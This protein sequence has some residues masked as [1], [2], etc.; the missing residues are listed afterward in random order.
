MNKYYRNLM[1]TKVWGRGVALPLHCVKCMSVTLW[2]RKCG[3]VSIPVGNDQGIIPEDLDDI[4]LYATKLLSKLLLFESLFGCLDSWAL[5]FSPIFIPVRFYLL[6]CQ[7]VYYISYFYFNS[8]VA[9]SMYKLKVFWQQCAALFLITWPCNSIHSSVLNF[10]CL[11][12][13]TL[14]YIDEIDVV[15]T[16]VKIGF[17]QILFSWTV[18]CNRELGS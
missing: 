1:P 12:Y 15:G 2:N 13:Q 5:F 4:I 10:W 9:S 14:I 3:R 11:W 18:F 17:L 6:P 8:F 7:I 16:L